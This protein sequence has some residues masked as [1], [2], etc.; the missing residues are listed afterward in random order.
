MAAT[1]STDQTGDMASPPPPSSAPDE[2]GAPRGTGA[3]ALKEIISKMRKQQAMRMTPGGAILNLGLAYFFPL[4][5]PTVS[6]VC[7]AL[8]ACTD[9]STWRLNHVGFVRTGVVA[10]W[11]A[12]C[13]YS[14]QLGFF[15]EVQCLLGA[16]L[17]ISTN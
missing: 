10:S 11:A 2:P 17:A 14:G 15:P 6:L 13:A 16:F 7:N 8:H 4:F 3:A 9:W 12:Y 5:L 1:D